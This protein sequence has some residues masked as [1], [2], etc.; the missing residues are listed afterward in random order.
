MLFANYPYTD[1]HE[2][3]LDWILKKIKELDQEVDDF[4]TFNKIT[5]AGAWDG[6]AY[7][8]WTIVDDGAGNGYLSIRA[9]PANVPLSNTDYWQPVSQYTALYNAFDARIS[10]LEASMQNKTVSPMDYGAAGDGVTDDSAAVSA[11][12]AAGVI[13]D[14]AHTFYCASPVTL[15]YG[16]LYTSYIMK[17]DQPIINNGRLFI[18]NDVTSD[19]PFSPVRGNYLLTMTDIDSALI[20]FNKF[21]NAKNAVYL[22]RCNNVIFTNNTVSNMQQTNSNGYGIVTS[23][24]DRLLIDSNIFK[25]CDRHCVYISHDSG[26]LGSTDVVISNNMIDLSG[27]VNMTP[28]A[29]PIQTRNAHKVQIHENTVRNAQ[30]FV[31]IIIDDLSNDASNDIEISGNHVTDIKAPAGREN[32]DGCVSIYQENTAQ[33]L[34]G[35][36]IHDNV[37]NTTDVLM[38]KLSAADDVTIENN[39]FTSGSLYGIQIAYGSSKMFSVGLRILNNDVKVSSS[40]IFFFI[41]DLDDIGSVTINGNTINAG[42]I[43]STNVASFTE[44]FD[45]LQVCDNKYESPN[46]RDFLNGCPIDK[47]V[48]KGN[49]GNIGKYITATPAAIESDNRYNTIAFVASGSSFA[50]LVDNVAS[51]APYW[52][53]NGYEKSDFRLKSRYYADVAALPTTDVVYGQIAITNDSHAY[54]W[55]GDAWLQLG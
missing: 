30:G 48:V 53:G 33:K 6:S 22:T 51:S 44:G 8:K 41:L 25:A 4:V 24:C 37:F 10:A 23:S 52:I 27:A 21:Y 9:V 11:A 2:L 42:Y 15:S 18:G 47:L 19:G 26:T 38:A 14:A 50:G 46:Y 36:H 31:W 17:E 32:M 3:N 49:N 7:P 1:F 39:K 40:G 35:L 55:K 45:L 43:F 20:A 28:T 34:T 54:I 16:S 29:F 5:F 13:F 12:G